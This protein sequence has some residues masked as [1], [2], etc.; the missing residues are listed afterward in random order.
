VR[1]T[2]YSP[3]RHVSYD[4]AT[5]DK[6]GVGG[7]ITARIRIARSLAE[8]GHDVS[9]V[10]NT[11]KDKTFDGVHYVPLDASKR[12]DADVLVINSSGGALDLSP[13]L[14]LD[15]DAKLRAVWV[16]GIDPPKALDAVGMDYLYA[17]SNFIRTLARD[18][19]G[20]AQEKIYVTHNGVTRREPGRKRKPPARDLHRLIYNSH[21]SKGLAAAI[22]VVRLLRKED[23]RFELHVYGGTQLWGQADKPPADEPGVVYHGLIGQEEL[24]EEMERAGFSMN[25]QARLEPFALAPAEAMAA[26][27]IVV[28]S[29]VGGYP[30]LIRHGYNGFLVPRDHNAADTQ[31]R[32]AR[33]IA[34]V[35]RRDDF[36][37]FIRRNATP[38]PHDWD[39]LARAWVGHWDWALGGAG[40]PSESAWSVG[41]QPCGECGGEFLALADGYHCESCGYHTRDGRDS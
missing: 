23:P 25:L 18:S 7:G 8:Q 41:F 15:V 19:W 6:V 3:D 9:V 32:A 12:I 29:P 20:V 1:V 26:G 5:T 14:D 11:P 35:A 40:K 13:L 37:S 22:E 27:C 4:G 36:A 16:Q 33:L 39:T 31:Q 28:A 21:P 24:A 30:E 34:D 38:W 10:A 2:I 17:P